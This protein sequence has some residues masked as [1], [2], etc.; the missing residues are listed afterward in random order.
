MIKQ[1]FKRVI[2]NNLFILKYAFK[3]TPLYLITS[4]LYPF[5]GAI[6]VFFEHTYCIKYLTDTIQYKGPFSDVVTYISVI[7]VI[8]ALKILFGIFYTQ[9]I[10]LN[11]KEKLHKNIQM[12]LFQKAAQIDLSCYDNPEYYNEF[13]WSI[14]EA[15]NRVDKT[16]EYL[17]KFCESMGVILT[18]GTL[19]L[20]FNKMGLIFVTMSFVLI[21]LTDIEI[22]KLGFKM[23]VELKPKQRKRSYINRVFY[24]TDY[25][26]EIR[27]N[28]I[29]PKLK[30]DFNDTNNDILNTIN[31]YSKKQLIL[32]FLNDY[33]F[34]SFILDGLYMIYLLFIAVVKQSISAGTV[35]ALLSS[36]RRMKSNLKGISNLIP[37]FQQNSLYIEKMRAFLDYKEVIK[38]IDNAKS[39]PKE[40]SLLELKNVSFAYSEKS[41]EILKNISIN[42]RPYEKIAFVGYNGAGKTTLTKLLMRLYDVSKGE[43]LLNNVNIKNYELESYR[44]SFGTVF[45][46]YQIFAANI[47]ENVIMDEVTNNEKDIIINAL[48]NSGFTDKLTSYK[49]G[50]CTPLTREFEENGVNIS[51]GEAQKIAIARVFAKPCQIIILDEPSSALDP[52]SEYNLN[53][54]MLE[55]AANKTVI[56]ISH[57]LSSARM[58]DRIYM[59][60]KGEIIEQGSHEELMNFDGKYAEMFNLQAEKYKF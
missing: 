30:M 21:L 11:S 36:A 42:I 58:A 34:N 22:N 9:Y 20:L 41:G 56:F 27:L 39:V 52:I 57:R 35:I 47:A 44:N 23:D 49:N 53:Q 48:E 7:S 59:L 2:Q 26:K 15:T 6:V 51:G 45:Q 28:N 10:E 3:Y 29:T 40:P 54:T 37:Q 16:I 14:S 5:L 8:V 19:F 17:Y 50:I 46:D 4:C 1:S 43:I 31:K 12:E 55:A 60:E 33:I 25:A 32:G 13:V 38:N 24:L 18:T